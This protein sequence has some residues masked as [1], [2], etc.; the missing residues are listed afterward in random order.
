MKH[1]IPQGNNWMSFIP[2]STKLSKLAIPGTHDSAAYKFFP[3]SVLAMT[4]LKNIK[5]QLKLGIRFLDIR[6]RQINNNIYMYHWVFDL[7]QNLDSV[8]KTCYKFLDENPSET[9]IFCIQ[10]EE[11]KAKQ[12]TESYYTTLKRIYH[13]QNPTKWFIDD[14]IPKL[15]EVR[16]KIVLLRK[17]DF[18][19]SDHP[20]GGSRIF[21][22]DLQTGWMKNNPNTEVQNNWKL[23]KNHTINQK[24]EE[25]QEFFEKS[26][27]NHNYNKL[28]LN[29]CSACDWSGVFGNVDVARKIIPNVSKFYDRNKVEHN[30]ACIVIMDFPSKR[31]IENIYWWSIRRFIA[32]N[33]TSIQLRNKHFDEYLYVADSDSESKKKR[34]V[35]TVKKPIFPE[36]W[37]LIPIKNEENTF[38]IYNPAHGE[39]LFNS[40]TD[41]NS[42]QRNVSTYKKNGMI[43][44]QEEKF[45]WKFEYTNASKTECYIYNKHFHKYL[46]ASESDFATNSKKRR[47]VYTRRKSKKIDGYVWKIIQ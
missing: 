30:L 23:N 24:I 28:Y 11:S 29:F 21:G 14:K 16:G 15:S 44:G 41:G 35:Y 1:K 31:S 34:Q 27:K 4:Q 36:M 26:I 45:K 13:A 12:N 42:I 38:Y 39:Y 43:E 10:D 7:E 33:K 19:S 18:Q 46:Y 9:I 2:D 17:F 40:K 32:V 47:L 22:L 5:D 3:K 37:V 25:I 6:G 20:R 8:L